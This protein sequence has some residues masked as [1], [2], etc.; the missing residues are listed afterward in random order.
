PRRAWPAIEKRSLSRYFIKI[1]E[2]PDSINA[3]IFS[4]TKVM[5][6][7]ERNKKKQQIVS[8]PFKV[9]LPSRTIRRQK[10]LTTKIVISTLQFIC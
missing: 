9:F 1:D 10:V 4:I 2:F 6:F 5:S 8:S 3:A 7:Y